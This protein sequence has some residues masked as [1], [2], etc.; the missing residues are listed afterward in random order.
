MM[1][2]KATRQRR[3]SYVPLLVVGGLLAAGAA[4]SYF[5]FIRPPAPKPLPQ[6][7]AEAK[8]Y[9]RHLGLSG[10]EMKAAQ[11]FVGGTVVEI[12]GKITNGGGR[13]LRLVE[14]N[15]VFADPYGQVVLRERVPIVRDKGAVF[16]PGE[17]RA[18]RLPF[19]SIPQTWNQTMPQLVIA[20]IDFD[21]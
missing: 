5:L 9:V 12:T 2:V 11:S 20:R 13:R 1:A 15:C 3:T 16:Q 10:T 6:L 21:E 4:L 7:S 18:F 8:T 17:T 19:D 14:L